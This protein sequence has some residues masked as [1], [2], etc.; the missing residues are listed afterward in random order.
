MESEGN[1]IANTCSN[2]EPLTEE[3]VG[4]TL[5]EDDNINKTDPTISAR[6][7]ILTEKGKDFKV[8]RLKQS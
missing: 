3:N 1:A 6:F 5:N 4:D 8:Q 2:K 7:Q